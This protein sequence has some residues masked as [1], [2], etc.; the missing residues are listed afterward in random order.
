MENLVVS[1]QITYAFLPGLSNLT[2]RNLTQGYAGKDM[3]QHIQ[4][5]I[6]CGFIYKGK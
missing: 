2:S 4:S 6:H 3:K 1:N 5:T